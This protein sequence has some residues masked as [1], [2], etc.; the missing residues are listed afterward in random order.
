[1]AD[2]LHCTK[3]ISQEVYNQQWGMF[4]FANICSVGVKNII[5]G[6]LNPWNVPCDQ[7]ESGEPTKIFMT[8]KEKQNIVR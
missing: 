4:H 8:D 3:N 5:N 1:M 6:K 2:C 7:F